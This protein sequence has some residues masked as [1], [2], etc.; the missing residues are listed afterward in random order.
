MLGLLLLNG[1][2]AE[3]DDRKA[4]A[5]ISKAAEQGLSQAQN[6]LATLYAQGRGLRRDLQQ[7]IFWLRRS[8]DQ[9]LPVARE[10]LKRFREHP[11]QRSLHSSAAPLPH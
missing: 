3:Q 6:D 10:N 9:G 7:A 8:A 2:G 5:W 4:A 11:P 1:T